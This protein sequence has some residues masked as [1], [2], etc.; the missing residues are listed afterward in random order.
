LET[1]YEKDEKPVIILP[2]TVV[3]PLAVVIKTL[4]TFFAD[5]TMPG[6][7]CTKELTL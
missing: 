1:Y 5:E 6:F 7:W 3:Y 2:N 4:N